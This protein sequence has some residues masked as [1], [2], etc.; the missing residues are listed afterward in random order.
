MDGHLINLPQP[1]CYGEQISFR[2]TVINRLRRPELR[3]QKP[4]VAHAQQL[5]ERISAKLT[6]TLRR[7]STADIG[8][9]TTRPLAAE[10]TQRKVYCT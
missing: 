5:D 2:M 6:S 9:C 8:H 10:S 3:A 1:D 4:A 7:M